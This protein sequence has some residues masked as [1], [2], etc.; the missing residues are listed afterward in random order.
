VTTI[1]RASIGAS[2]YVVRRASRVVQCLLVFSAQHFAS[3][4]PYFVR[5]DWAMAKRVR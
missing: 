4:A 3:A 1:G 5:L 2:R